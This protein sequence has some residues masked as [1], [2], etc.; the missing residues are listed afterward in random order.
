MKA[1]SAAGGEFI[2]KN[3]FGNWKLNADLRH[4]I[5]KIL[6]GVHALYVY[7]KDTSRLYAETSQESY[8]SIKFEPTDDLRIGKRDDF[9]N[10][11]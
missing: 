9:L 6:Y 1:N 4:G 2:T 10:S 3:N 7:H 5:N 11:Y 8:S